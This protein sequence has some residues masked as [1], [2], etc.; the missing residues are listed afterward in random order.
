MSLSEISIKFNTAF[1][2]KH[3]WD[4]VFYYERGRSTQNVLRGSV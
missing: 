3:P 2:E 1:F 4:F